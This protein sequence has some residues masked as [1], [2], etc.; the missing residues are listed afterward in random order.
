[1]HRAALCLS[2]CHDTALS[3]ACLTLQ[4]LRFSAALF[5]VTPLHAYRGRMALRY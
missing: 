2:A 4:I 5:V 3:P 1:M